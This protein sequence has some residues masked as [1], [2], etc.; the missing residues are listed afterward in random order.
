MVGTITLY[1]RILRMGTVT[2]NMKAPHL[3]SLLSDDVL[4]V[5]TSRREM[6][7][8]EAGPGHDSK[9]Y[10]GI[11]ALKWVASGRATLTM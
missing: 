4:L 5:A 1:E 2:V 7:Q 3:W 6:E 10:T 11:P 9:L 8:I